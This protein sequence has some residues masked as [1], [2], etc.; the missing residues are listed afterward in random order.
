[1]MKNKDFL[2]FLALTATGVF[3][4]TYPD[5]DVVSTAQHELYPGQNI[6][7]L[8]TIKGSPCYEAELTIEI[9]GI[10]KPLYSYE[11]KFN[12]LT[13][14]HWEGIT[15]QDAVN[16]AKQ[17][18]GEENIIH[19]KK[20][21]PLDSE[22]FYVTPLVPPKLYNAYKSSNC[23]AFHHEIHYEAYTTIVIPQGIT[24]AV[25]VNNFGI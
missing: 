17:V 15:E 20:L 7:I 5:C 2:L 25:P 18:S 14:I 3:A 6:T 24:K 8:T 10:D 12:L 4:E 11:A 21:E 13:A 22:W 19:C 23:K 1:M 9:R 16:F